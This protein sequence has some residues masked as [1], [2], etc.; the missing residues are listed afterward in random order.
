MSSKYFGN[1]N[2]KTTQQQKN[3]GRTNSKGAK[4]TQIKKAGRG[5]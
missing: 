5:K 2:N 1:K 4:S 3:T